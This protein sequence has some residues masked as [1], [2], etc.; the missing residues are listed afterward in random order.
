[1]TSDLQNNLDRI[2]RELGVEEIVELLSERIPGTDLNTLL[3]EVFREKTNTSSARELFTRYQ[4]N[5]FVQPA[6]VDPIRW[7]R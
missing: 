4:E 6:T 5:R 3:L 1:M 7:I 2:V